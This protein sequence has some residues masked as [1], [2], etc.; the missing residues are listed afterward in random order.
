VSDLGKFHFPAA[1]LLAESI[2]LGERRLT[3]E[4][5]TFAP[6][7]EMNQTNSQMQFLQLVCVVLVMA[8]LIGLVAA[9]ILYRDVQNLDRQLAEAKVET[10][11]CKSNRAG[12]SEELETLKNIAGYQLREVGEEG[13]VETATI[14]GKIRE[15]IH[16]FLGPQTKPNLRDAMIQLHDQLGHVTEE[17]NKLKKEL[18]NLARASASGI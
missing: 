18:E 2:I 15:D 11:L 16:R 13:S 9:Y 7:N 14:V 10:D 6:G 17:R 4:L 1:T 8:T 12:L 3:A 5:Q